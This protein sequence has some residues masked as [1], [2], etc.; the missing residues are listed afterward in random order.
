M[1]LYTYCFTCKAKIKVASGALDRHELQMEKGAE[2]KVICKK[3]KQAEMRHINEIVA[4]AN[5]T[6]TLL[7]FFIAILISILLWPFIEEIGT[8]SLVV[9][10][11]LLK[12]QMGVVKIFNS[13]EIKK[14]R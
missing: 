1:K 9:P 8:L 13:V 14:K 4:Q 7:S 2:F 5:N 12:Q 3:C 11:L 10:F 6:V